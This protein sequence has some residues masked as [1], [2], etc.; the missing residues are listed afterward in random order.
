MKAL[1]NGFVF[2][3]ETATLVAQHETKE[4]GNSYFYVTRF[5][6][7]FVHEVPT[8]KDKE[9]GEVERL[10]HLEGGVEELDDF[11]EELN[12]EFEEKVVIN[13]ENFQIG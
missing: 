3:T 6:R 12:S 11:F 1:S 13:L 4:F 2:D 8:E 5:G 10:R 7:Y 9:E